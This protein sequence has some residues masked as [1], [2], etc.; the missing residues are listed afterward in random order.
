MPSQDDYMDNLL[1][2]IENDPADTNN[3]END[4]TDTNDTED[5]PDDTNN[6]EGN[7]FV[8]DDSEDIDTMVENAV[9]DMETV[10]G[11]ELGFE[12]DAEH[13][14]ELLSE[15]DTE[16][17]E[18]L[19]SEHNADELDD[20]D[21]DEIYSDIGL[22]SGDNGE[23]GTDT[24]TDSIEQ[25]A[26]P[27]LDALSSMSEDDIE[28][29]LSVGAGEESPSDDGDILP[30][31]EELLNMLNDADDD[32]LQDI[33]EMLHKADKNEAVDDSLLQRDSDSENGSVKLPGG[34]D[35]LQNTLSEKE[36]L[37]QQKKLR[38]QEKAAAKAA[39]KAQKAAAKAAAKAEKAAAKAAAKTGAAAAGGVSEGAQDEKA[40]TENEK[41]GS[42]NT[43]FDTSLLDSIV[44]GSE[45]AGTDGKVTAAPEEPGNA[46]FIEDTEE[47]AAAQ[48]ESDLDELDIDM[49]SLIEE[50]ENMDRF[51]KSQS[52]SHDSTAPNAGKGDASNPEQGEPEPKKGG[53]I[54]KIFD[55][56]TEDEDDEESESLQ[57]SEEN[58]DILD[59]LDN[60]KAGGKKK[61][62]SAS[63]DGKSV[64]GKAKAQKSKAKKPNPPKKPKK[65]KKP[66]P[67]K[68]KKEKEPE[69]EPLIPER[70]LT[71]KRVMP[72]VLV[73]ASFGV[74][75]I[76]LINSSIDFTDKQAAEEAYYAGDYQTC[77][78]NLYGKNLNETEQIMFGKSES[79]LYIRLWIRE[80]EMFA[81]DG[82]EVEALD[83][84]LQ[85]V[86][87]YPK[88]YDY[89]V[90]WDAGAEVAA[91]YQ[92]ILNILLEK[93]GLT[94][95]QAK[96][97]AAE[98]SD[99]KYT[100]M[101][102]EIIYGDGFSSGNGQTSASES[103]QQTNNQEPDQTTMQDVLPEEEDL[104]EGE[105]I[106]N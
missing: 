7:G 86:S 101:I 46:S 45:R 5:D 90:Q 67:E 18:V 93:Y 92:T 32:D 33:H 77:F 89:A 1:K 103:E 15:L 13:E 95:E 21:L 41:K 74:F 100:R 6:I 78:Q 70:K 81:Q 36:Q 35:D 68:P 59:D 14:D 62:K 102:V 28:K 73:C 99:R 64:K 79:I 17:G 82:A 39:A 61:K 53:L 40:E 63:D 19:R 24:K 20:L 23:K 43:H 37:A 85:T 49:D 26:V 11:E 9:S 54:S 44:A 87:D 31:D 94:E 10:Y 22:Y 83:S 52:K 8:V 16:S 27:D 56:L 65:A 97:I 3:I 50:S 34:E 4:P 47:V 60:E 30:D 58:R 71:L 69:P 57:L 96:E 25:D 104:D 80:Y 91:G 88:L 84:L 55:F 48:D 76:V 2:N 66:K 98:S 72:V 38:K 29:L 12:Q 106:G 75:I 51:S 42:P 105:F